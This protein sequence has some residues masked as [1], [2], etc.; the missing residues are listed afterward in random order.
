MAKETK[1]KMV[2]VV[3]DDESY[4][5]A[6]QRL[7]KSADLPVRLFTRRGFSEFWRATR[8][9]SPYRGCSHAW[10]VR[11]RTTQFATQF[12]VKPNFRIDARGLTPGRALQHSPFHSSLEFNRVM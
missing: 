4:R 6:L 1:E 10:N 7:L 8:D 9:R 2:S 11:A 12:S 3:E 5:T